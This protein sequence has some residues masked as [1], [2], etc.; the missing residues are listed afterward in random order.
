VSDL[1]LYAITDTLPALLDS[2]DMC[3]SDEQRAECEAE[4]QRYFAA[5]PQKVDGVARMIAHYEG[6]SASA[7]AEL[8][9]LADRKRRFDARL[10]SLKAY[11]VR[12]LD[13]L[14]EP[15]RGAK[16]LEGDT[17]TLSLKRCP[18]SLRITD[19]TKIPP[20]YMTI[21]PARSEVCNSAVKDALKAGT[22]VPGAELV[23]DKR[24]LEVS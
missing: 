23:T 24:R 2:L 11:V 13:A 20:E 12:V 21:I 15:R 4:I 16:R 3:E 5:L 18:P 10:D 17:A 14:P 9:R 22:E 6:Q 19:A 1:T 8:K 7:S